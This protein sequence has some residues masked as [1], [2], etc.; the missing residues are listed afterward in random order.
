LVDA[1][2]RESYGAGLGL[3]KRDRLPPHFISE[4][5]NLVDP[6]IRDYSD[7]LGPPVSFK[8]ALAALPS[9]E[10]TDGIERDRRIE[11]EPKPFRNAKPSHGFG[12]S[13]RGI[14]VV[15]VL[16]AVVATT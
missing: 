13:G 14:A 12:P 5:D 6:S 4:Q 16:G 8:E 3:P 11:L 7:S 10:D 15:Y 2:N 1:L 9:R